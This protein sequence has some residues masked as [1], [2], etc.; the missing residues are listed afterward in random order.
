M[1]QSFVH[2]IQLLSFIIEYYSVSYLLIQL[3]AVFV[4]CE[5][6]KETLC[7]L[8]V[9]CYSE[10][11]LD[12]LSGYQADQPPAVYGQSDIVC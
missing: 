6:F 2:C 12:T 3:A 9:L 4:W 8:T 7:I 10:S 5:I 1:T 11:A